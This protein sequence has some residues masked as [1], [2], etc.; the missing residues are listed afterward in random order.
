MTEDRLQ[1]LLDRCEI[2]RIVYDYATGL[3]TK[4][5]SLW[6][7]IFT[8]EVQVKFRP[9]AE[10]EF[11][12]LG[13]EWV[14]MSADE[15]VE[16]RRVLFTGLA[17]TQHQMSNPRIT[18]EGDT[19]TCVMYMQAIH[20]MPGAPDLEYTI[21][22]YYIDDLVR[23]PEG[24]KLARVNLNVTWERGDATMLDRARELGRQLVAAK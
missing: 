24:W 19:A 5:W 7:S 17:T 23:T 22:G 18:V 8:D 4:D 13:Q 10:A 2:E 1:L 11:T 16:G 3:D 20:F 14:S 6:R 21:G 9:A 12:G 15:W